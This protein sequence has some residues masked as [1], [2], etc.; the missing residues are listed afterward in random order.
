MSKNSEELLKKLE[1][2]CDLMPKNAIDEIMRQAGG[3]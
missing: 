1:S 3:H 2:L